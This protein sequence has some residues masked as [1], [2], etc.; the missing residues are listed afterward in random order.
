VRLYL[1][2]AGPGRVAAVTAAIWTDF[3]ATQPGADFT[4]IHTHVTESHD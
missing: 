1:D 4:R 3:A 2:E